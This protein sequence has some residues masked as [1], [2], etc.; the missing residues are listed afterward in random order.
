[1]RGLLTVLVGLGAALIAGVALANGSDEPWEPACPPERA[2]PSKE[3]V[4]L[5]RALFLSSAISPARRSCATCHEPTHGYGASAATTLKFKDLPRSIPSLLN[6]SHQRW[7]F[8]DGRADQLWQ[9]AVGPLESEAE[10]N[11]H[12]L[13]MVAA[14]VS[15]T[16]LRT[17]AMAGGALGS[18]ELVALRAAL[19]HSTASACVNNESCER[20][21]QTLPRDQRAVVEAIAH[22][23]LLS[24]AAFQV[25]L[26]SR[27]TAYDDYM[28]SGK[29]LSERQ[30][31]GMKLFFGEARCSS[32]HS[33]PA[34]TDAGFHNLLLPSPPGRAREDPGRFRGI[35]H[36]R[37]LAAS[38]DMGYVPSEIAMHLDLNNSVWGQ[39]KTP[40][41][42]NLEGRSEFMHNGVYKNLRD[43]LGYYNTLADA[44]VVHHHQNALLAPLNFKEDQLEDLEAFLRIFT[45]RRD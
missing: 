16:K 9:Q 27:W 28:A 5:G 8:W 42:R 12:R 44:Q 26:K 14:V 7:F 40:S 37:A 21:W 29:G 31:R 32:C 1:M 41:I 30:L 36:L 11:S 15:N 43:V 25:S 35:Q 20:A 45:R 10:M 4:E 33:G 38:G 24:L 39:F 2:C 34:M 13:F 18:R 19:G 17:S 23:L 3:T 6:L 22:K